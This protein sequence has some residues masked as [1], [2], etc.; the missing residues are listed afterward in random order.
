MIPMKDTYYFNFEN[1]LI[2]T[3]GSLKSDLLLTETTDG[4][5]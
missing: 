4:N 3:M 1:W 5:K 2:S